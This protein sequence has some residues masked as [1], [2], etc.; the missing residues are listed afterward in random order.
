MPL[1]R[2]QP[3]PVRASSDRD[4]TP[5]PGR[6]NARRAA[7]GMLVLGLLITT[8]AT[9]WSLER[10]T[11]SDAEG[12]RQRRVPDGSQPSAPDT[13]DGSCWLQQGTQGKR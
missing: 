8:L 11:R 7:I 9:W 1:L 13:T 6:T 5:N 12:L 10:R 2:D 4:P 3:A